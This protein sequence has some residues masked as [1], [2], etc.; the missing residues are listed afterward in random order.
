MNTYKFDRVTII[1]RNVRTANRRHKGFLRGELDVNGKTILAN[2]RKP[3]GRPMR[4]IPPSNPDK[5]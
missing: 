3:K 4:K 2:R 1:A 5:E